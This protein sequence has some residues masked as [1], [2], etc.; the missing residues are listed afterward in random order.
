MGLK[1][2]ADS[3]DWVSD[4]NDV[5]D[6]I[7]FYSGNKAYAHGHECKG[8]TLG[9]GLVTWVGSHLRAVVS[10]IAFPLSASLLFCVI[11]CEPIHLILDSV[12][13]YVRYH[14]NGA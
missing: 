8:T 11:L 6:I 5:I 2:L 7:V 4:D 1:D 3:R 9:L 13:I 10:P 14:E 12:G